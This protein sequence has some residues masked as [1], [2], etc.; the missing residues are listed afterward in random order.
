MPAKLNDKNETVTISDV[1]IVN[2]GTI[3]QNAQDKIL[4]EIK[5]APYKNNTEFMD[6]TRLINLFEQYYPE[7]FL[8]GAWNHFCWIA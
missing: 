8:M 4:Y 1:C 7:F 5:E 6:I 3:T 2:L